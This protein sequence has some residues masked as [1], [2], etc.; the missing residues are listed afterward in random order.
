MLDRSQTNGDRPV[1]SM[2]GLYVARA[3]AE[4]SGGGLK[5]TLPAEDR[6]RLVAGILPSAKIRSQAG[7]QTRSQNRFEDCFEHRFEAPHFLTPL[8]LDAR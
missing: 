3:L 8:I 5:L 1:K 6:M 4:S 2:V 7:P